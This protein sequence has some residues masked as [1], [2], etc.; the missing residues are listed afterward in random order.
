MKTTFV[1]IPL[2]QIK[3]TRKEHFTLLKVVKDRKQIEVLQLVNETK[4][5]KILDVYIT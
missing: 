2:L 3:K 5:K 4:T 1:G